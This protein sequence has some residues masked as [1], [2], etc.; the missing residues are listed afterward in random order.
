MVDGK[1]SD[2]GSKTLVEPE[3]IPPVHGDKVSKPLVG[4]LVSYNIS[5]P[6]SVAVCG[7]GGVEKYC[8][9]SADINIMSR[10]FRNRSLPVGDETPVLHGAV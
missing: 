9:S 3:L 2:P 1:P 8:G 6:V 5:H 10:Q 4:K 7:C